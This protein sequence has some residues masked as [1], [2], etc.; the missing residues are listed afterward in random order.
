MSAQAEI[1]TVKCPWCGW[2]RTERK[3]FDLACLWVSHAN[4][5][6]DV[7]PGVHRAELF[8][9]G[10]PTVDLSD[11][12]PKQRPEGEDRP[13]RQIRGERAA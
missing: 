2:S 3:H 6:H 13:W 11:L 12:H 4:Y 5:Q 10:D 8:V 9:L 7:W 1:H